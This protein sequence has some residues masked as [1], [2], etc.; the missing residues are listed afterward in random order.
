MAQ[1]IDQSL[2]TQKL[3]VQEFLARQREDRS[4]TAIM[5]RERRWRI[6][7]EPID[8]GDFWEMFET[9]VRDNG[10]VNMSALSAPSADGPTPTIFIVNAAYQTAVAIVGLCLAA[11]AAGYQVGHDLGEA[12][13]DDTETEPA[14]G[15]GGDDGGD[16]DAPQN[17]RSTI[18]LDPDPRAGTLT[19]VV[20]RA[21]AGPA[22]PP[23]APQVTTQEVLAQLKRD[24]RETL[25]TWASGGGARILGP[26]MSPRE[27]WELIDRAVQPDGT[28]DLEL[29]GARTSSAAASRADLKK[30]IVV[31]AAAALV[32]F[33]IGVAV[34][35]AVETMGDHEEDSDTETDDAG[36]TT[37]TSDTGTRQG[38]RFVSGTLRAGDELGIDL[39]VRA[40][41]DVNPED[42]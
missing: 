1:I 30:A 29:F 41:R 19:L 35:F 33:G 38:S 12:L 11:G 42:L 22:D 5:L 23:T 28:I 7:S 9:V 40:T 15:D 3:S 20:T 2:T 17:E 32:S 14:D 18:V 21:L 8:V 10:S 36:G 26:T 31:V 6:A 13:D 27:F 39:R 37:D 16:D 24:R 34:G 4:G 25:R